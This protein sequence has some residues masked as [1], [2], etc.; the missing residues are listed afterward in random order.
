M[1]NFL[2]YGLCVLLFLFVNSAFAWTHSIEIGYGYSHD[3]NNIHYNNSGVLI[4]GDIFAIKRY[5][6]AFWS[7]SG[8]LGQWHTTA[9]HNKDLTT[10]ALSLALRLYPQQILIHPFYVL[11]SVGPAALSSRK[12]CVNTQAKNLTIQTILGLGM[13]F[14]NIDAN[15]HLV[16]YSNAHLATPNQGFNIL[17]MLSIGYLF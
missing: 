13:E 2:K 5:S 17:Y 16:H 3:P 15:F 6:Q 8:A 9:P 12:F 1:K 14:K 11:G 4:N 10:A 7:I